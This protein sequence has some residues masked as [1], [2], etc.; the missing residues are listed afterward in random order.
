MT[1]LLRRTAALLPRSGFDT[2][3]EVANVLEALPA[4]TQQALALLDSSP[5]GTAEWALAVLPPGSRA[6]LEM[7]G[8]A[9]FDEA[10]ET[11]DLQPARIT[12]LGRAVIHACAEL[13]DVSQLIGAEPDKEELRAM[14][15]TVL[16]GASGS[17]ASSSLSSRSS[18]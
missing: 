15:E 13:H 5:E 6:V 14:F 10:D 18:A 4:P 7:F 3:T 17:S 8:A 11:H 9:Q 2:T 12:D 1:S 16:S